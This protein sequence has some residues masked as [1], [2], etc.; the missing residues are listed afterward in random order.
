MDRSWR[1]DGTADRGAA[2]AAGI[3][4]RFLRDLDL[5]LL[6]MSSDSLI[7]ARHD[8][9][10]HSAFF[11]LGALTACGRLLAASPP[12]LWL[13]PV[14]PRR[15]RRRRRSSWPIFHPPARIYFAIIHV[16]LQSIFDVIIFTWATP[17]P[18]AQNGLI[19]NA[20]A[21]VDPS[22]MTRAS[23]STTMDW[24]VLAV[25]VGS[26]LPA[27]YAV[28][29]R[30]AT[31]WNRSAERAAQPRHRLSG[32]TLQDGVGHAVG[33]VRRSCRRALRDPERIRRGAGNFVDFRPWVD[34]AI[35]N[36]MGGIGTL[37]GLIVGAGF[38]QLMRE[39]NRRGWVWRSVP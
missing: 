7:G 33:A 23:T 13:H 37:V 25:V 20:P 24:F 39:L 15:R 11:G 22:L 21:S 19:F 31:F 34:S 2:G 4:R 14:R 8:P 36:V 38:F 35:D 27:G 9:F 5:G 17:S 28:A 12:N 29:V 16:D 10:G 26:P 18:A 3:L 6:A 32:R 30:H 1:G